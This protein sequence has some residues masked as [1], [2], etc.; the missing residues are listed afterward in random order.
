PFSIVACVGSAGDDLESRDF[1][2]LGMELPSDET[3]DTLPT[4]HP[5]A[6]K[7]PVFG[8]RA[9][10]IRGAA[11]QLERAGADQGVLVRGGARQPGRL[12]EIV[13]G[14]TGQAAEASEAT[15][16]AIRQ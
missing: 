7:E 8:C 9:A 11:E 12:G 14:S 10:P 2:R 16:S 4:L 6:V 15:K 3:G 1:R 13:G 5:R